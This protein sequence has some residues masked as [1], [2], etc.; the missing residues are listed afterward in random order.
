MTLKVMGSTSTSFQVDR[1]PA[2]G[3]TVVLSLLDWPG[4]STDTGDLADPVD[5]LAEEAGVVLRRQRARV[6]VAFSN[7]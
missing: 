2:A 5:A 6:A 7:P 3:G 4:Y 1:V